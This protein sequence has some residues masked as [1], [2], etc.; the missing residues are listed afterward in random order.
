M[1]SLD[2]RVDVFMDTN[3]ASQFQNGMHL[4]LGIG[5]AQEAQPLQWL[6]NNE[7]QQVILPGG[8]SFLPQR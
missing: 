1:L 6:P 3:Y 2:S 8:P 4:P 7:N 5:G